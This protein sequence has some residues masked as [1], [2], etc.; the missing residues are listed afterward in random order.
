VNAGITPKR[1]AEIVASG[2]ADAVAFGRLFLA[3]PD[4]PARIQ[5]GGPY[6]DLRHVGV[7]GGQRRQVSRLPHSRTQHSSMPN[8]GRETVI[9]F[10]QI[11]AQQ[12]VRSRLTSSRALPLLR[13][14]VGQTR[15]SVP[16]VGMPD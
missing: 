12:A 11:S 8:D 9:T 10:Y 16:F 15:P 1:A 7:Y 14:T 6:N 4:L 3:N 2:E 5:T 13:S